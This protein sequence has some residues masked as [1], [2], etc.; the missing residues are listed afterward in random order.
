MIR[1]NFKIAIFSEFKEKSGGAYNE[2]QYLTDAI[3]KKIDRN[4]EFLLINNNE[5]TEFETSEKVTKIKFNL[6]KL[7]R[8][9]CYIRNFHPIFKKMRK[10]LFKNKFEQFLKKNNIDLIIFTGPSQY[11][12]YLENTD[13]VITIPDLCH[14][15]NNEFPE[16][17]KN[18][19]FDRREEIISNAKKAYLILT[20][21]KIIGDKLIEKYN[22]EKEKINIISQT[23]PQN[24]IK[25]DSNKSK[26]KENLPEDFIFFPAMYLPHKNH[27]LIIDSIEILNSKKNNIE[28]NAVFCGDDK[29]YLKKIQNYVNEKNLNDKI[30][31]LNFVDSNDLAAIYK[32]CFA[33]VMP[34]FSGPTNIPP[35]E[36]FYF[37]KP[38]LYSKI[39]NIEKE[40]KDAVYYIDPFEVNSLI[41]AIIDLKKNKSIY[42]KYQST[43]KKILDTNNFDIDVEKFIK[44]IYLLR[45]AQNSWKFSYDI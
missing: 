34:T 31:F 36:A 4:F 16:W 44:K 13:F 45:K 38:V 28:M 7:Q 43:G 27:K 5:F 8:F 40:Y 3:I 15:E 18:G 25:A 37:E 1:K 35:W 6:N 11:S 39:F 23:T 29:G 2:A 22:F 19:E 30:T 14:L 26:I 9:I 42:E 17:S 41:N 21:A 24:L 33:L 20:N 32:N 12:L 10:I